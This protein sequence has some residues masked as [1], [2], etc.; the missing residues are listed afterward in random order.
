MDRCHRIG[1]CKQ[2]TVF[3]LVAE[4]SID[5]RIFAFCESKAQLGA[6]VLC[7]DPSALVQ[8]LLMAENAARN[9]FGAVPSCPSFK[10]QSSDAP[11]Q[12]HLR[13]AREPQTSP[14]M[15]RGTLP[16]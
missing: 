4:H 14:C 9:D 8:Q 5:E 15:L 13:D 3:S 7:E 16:A 10:Q 2:V 11:A 1:Q 6:A 12:H